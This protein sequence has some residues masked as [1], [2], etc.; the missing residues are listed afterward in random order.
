MY[1]L[2]LV[3]KLSFPSLDIIYFIAEDVSICLWSVDN[4]TMAVPLVSP[5]SV[6]RGHNAAVTCCAFSPGGNL[7]A[8]GGKDR[9]RSC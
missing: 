1:Q 8:T 6:L 4:L 7:L 3:W 9:V 5:V 2:S